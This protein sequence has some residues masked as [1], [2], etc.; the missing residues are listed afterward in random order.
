MP[1]GGSRTIPC[2]MSL[3]LSL[4]LS[5]TAAQ[6][7]LL[8]A[9]LTETVDAYFDAWVNG[10]IPQMISHLTPDSEY[11]P[12]AA[13]TVSGR[14]ALRRFYQDFVDN[15]QIDL[16]WQY[17]QAEI[18]GDWGYVMGVYFIRYAPTGSGEEIARGGRFFMDLRRGPDGQWRIRREL[19]QTTTDPVP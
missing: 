9:E 18:Q 15:Y 7:G 13:A 4:F 1:A 3:I 10:R 16:R 12:N 19:T 11:H 14:E 8:A 5:T 6:D 17:E 2:V